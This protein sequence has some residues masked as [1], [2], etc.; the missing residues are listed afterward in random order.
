VLPVVANQL[1]DR[2]IIQ[3]EAALSNFRF[4]RRF[5]A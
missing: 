1:F 4:L 5:S 2:A 3:I